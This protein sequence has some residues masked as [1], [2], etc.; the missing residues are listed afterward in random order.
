MIVFSLLCGVIT[1]TFSNFG[2]M[3]TYLGMTGPKALFA[4]ISWLRKPAVLTSAVFCSL[5]STSASRKGD[6]NVY[7]AAL[8]W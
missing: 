6:R 7:N 5:G 2:M 3:L 4:L 1:Y 8:F